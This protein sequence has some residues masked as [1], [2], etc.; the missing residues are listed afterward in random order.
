LP[1]GSNRCN[2]HFAPAPAGPKAPSHR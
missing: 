2:G 1:R